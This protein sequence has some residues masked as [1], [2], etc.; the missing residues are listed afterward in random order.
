MGESP[1]NV[2]AVVEPTLFPLEAV[3][4]SLHALTDAMDQT[5]VYVVE[6]RDP[7]SGKLVALW[8]SSPMPFGTEDRGMRQAFKEWSAQ[9]WNA[10]GPFARA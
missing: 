4:V 8:S 10:T 9:V 5:V 3:A 7:I 2:N 6:S 1:P